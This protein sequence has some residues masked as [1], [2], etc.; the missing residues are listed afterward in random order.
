MEKTFF[1]V[2]NIEVAQKVIEVKSLKA[3]FASKEATIQED[4]RS[5]DQLEDKLAHLQE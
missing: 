4:L 3:E 5:K 2:G 1:S